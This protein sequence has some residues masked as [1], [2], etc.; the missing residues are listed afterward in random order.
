MKKLWL[1]LLFISFAFVPLAFAQVG[2]PGPSAELVP[3]ASGPVN[4]PCNDPECAG[5]TQNASISIPS[6][7]DLPKPTEL[8]S[9]CIKDFPQL[10]KG[11]DSIQNSDIFNKPGVCQAYA[12]LLKKY[13]SITSEPNGTGITKLNPAFAVNVD[14]MLNAVN[15]GACSGIKIISGYR[16]PNNNP[17]GSAGSESLHHQ[18]LAVDLQYPDTYGGQSA[19]TGSF[20]TCE[21]PSGGSACYKQVVAYTGEHS[22][23]KT[24]MQFFG[25]APSAYAGECNHFRDATGAEGMGPGMASPIVPAAPPS[26]GP[27]SQTSAPP[28]QTPAGQ[29]TGGLQNGLVN[30]NQQF[31]VC[32]Q[33]PLIIAASTQNCQSGNYLTTST[34]CNNNSGLLGI[35]GNSNC[36]NQLTCNNIGGTI[37][38]NNNN[39]NCNNSGL[40]GLFGGGS[41][42]CGSSGGLSDLMKYMQGMQLGQSLGNLLGGTSPSP[43]PPPPAP[44][45]PPLY[46]PLG[47]PAPLSTPVS[48]N[49][50]SGTSPIDQLLAS[51]KNNTPASNA[52][53]T[54]GTTVSVSTS[55][56][57]Q[58]QNP[59][60][61]LQN[62]SNSGTSSPSGYGNTSGQFA[63]PTSG[64]APLTVTVNFTTGPSC[65]DAYRLSWGDGSAAEEQV[66][67]P[68]SAGSACGQI[69]QIH[70]PQHTYVL[71]GTYTITLKQ[72][73]DLGHVTTATITVSGAG[74]S[75]ATLTN[76]V[77]QP[78]VA[79]SSMQQQLSDLNGQ[80]QAASN[81]IAVASGTTSPSVIGSALGSIK[82]AL[83]SIGTFL[84]N[85]VSGK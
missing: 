68:P 19:P 63:S 17:P 52:T 74:G 77:S 12:D 65:A 21:Q 15:T 71:A 7:S 25:K 42:N 28:Y 84:S 11:T 38:C 69:A 67:T 80:L 54:Q 60:F 51:L 62:G 50:T 10:G 29:Q 57:G 9:D 58:F 76:G 72:N 82:G 18:G 55:S 22:E 14:K 49:P 24:L 41:S 66:Y 31:V 48:T 56:V 70:N 39:T 64:P 46:N 83:T 1:A 79:S 81:S 26:G 44:L 35:F 36:N 34:T 8:S 43:A 6:S 23:I 27:I 4:A 3:P 73:P 2:E 59:T 78:V 53:N 85:L 20:H 45:P 75:T 30:Q 33:F 16:N 61:N 13:N 47:T 5:M 37:V 32:S 40:L